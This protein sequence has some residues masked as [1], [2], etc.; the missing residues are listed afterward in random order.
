M[1][2]QIVS[3]SSHVRQKK[4]TTVSESSSQLG[5]V[6]EVRKTKFLMQSPFFNS[7]LLMNLMMTSFFQLRLVRFFFF[8]I[9][10]IEGRKWK[11]VFVYESGKC[12]SYRPTWS[13]MEGGDC[14]NFLSWNLSHVIRLWINTFEFI[15]NMSRVGRNSI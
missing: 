5:S 15:M 10:K 2:Q 6:Q 7:F 9:E 1:S 11:R 14:G 4:F 8:C 13:K 12:Y 3:Y